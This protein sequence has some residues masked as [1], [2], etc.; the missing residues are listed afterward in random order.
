MSEDK[1]PESKKTEKAS[2]NKIWGKYK[3]AIIICGAV[4]SVALI[5]FLLG[6]RITY[7]P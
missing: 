2:F 4:L 7:A 3:A 1:E 5:L 6:F